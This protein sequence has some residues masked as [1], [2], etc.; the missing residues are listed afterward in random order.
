MKYFLEEEIWYLLYNLIRAGNKAEQIHKKIGDIHPKNILIDDNGQTKIFSTLSVPDQIDN[1]W[2]V[3]ENRNTE[4][5][6][7]TL[8]Y[9][10][11]PE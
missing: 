8:I 7:G 10:L 9:D 1:F 11:A 4:V 2:K 6:L 3:V 5:F